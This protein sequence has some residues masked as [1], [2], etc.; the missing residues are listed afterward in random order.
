MTITLNGTT[1]ITST[2]IT[3]TS[4]GNV[5]IGT[6]LPGER[7]DVYLNTTGNVSAK[8]GNTSGSVQLLQSNGLAYLYTAAN[9]PIAFSTSNTE[10]MRI[11]SAGRVTMPYQ[12]SFLAQ[13]VQS[14]TTYSSNGTL[15]P[16]PNEVFDVGNNYNNSTSRFTAPVT[17]VYMVSWTCWHD[18]AGNTGRSALYKNGSPYKSAAN[19]SPIST[20]HNAGG[21]QADG[22][23]IPVQLSAGDYIEVKVFDGSVRQFWMNYFSAHLIG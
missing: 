20:R 14:D 18:D 19:A 12:P 21:Y 22:V 5:G 7:L 4:D 23:A 16:F 9:Q 10:R 13:A 1:G 17:G 8:V 15:I 11:D 6:S 3:E 2:V